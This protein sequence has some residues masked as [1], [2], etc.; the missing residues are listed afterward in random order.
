MLGGNIIGN[1]LVRYQ[2]V[3]GKYQFVLKLSSQDLAGVCKT[4]L[5]IAIAL[6]SMVNNPK[7]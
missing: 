4:R 2:L 7:G 6:M 1:R 5:A 3:F